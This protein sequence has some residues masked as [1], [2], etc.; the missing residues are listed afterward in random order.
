MIFKITSQGSLGWKAALG[1]IASLTPEALIKITPNALEVNCMDESR[2]S[3]ISF[4]WDAKS[5]I[6]YNVKSE[7][8]LGVRIEDF[9]KIVDR[10]GPKDNVTIEDI[11]EGAA[12]EVTL[13]TKKQYIMKLINTLVED[14]RTPKFD[15]DISFDMNLSELQSTLDDIKLI[16]DIVTIEGHMKE[17]WF[18]GKG[19]S[20][21]SKSIVNAEGWGEDAKI[22]VDIDSIQNVLKS[23]KKSVERVTL[24]FGKEKSPLHMVLSAGDM[25]DINYYLSPIQD[26]PYN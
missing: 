22:K 5:F 23:V 1:S 26:S 14:S 17:I 13:G 24:S 18:T 7:L 21:T 10:A 8:S 15:I 3:L 12:I 20:G 19:D 4:K 11:N 25:G 9:L 16:S 2:V 6:E